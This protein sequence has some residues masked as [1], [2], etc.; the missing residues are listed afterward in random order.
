MKN[1]VLLLF[2]A[3]AA[4]SCS[5]EKKVNS[6]LSGT[7]EN[8][9]NGMVTLVGSEYE[10]DLILNDDGTF[11]SELELPY[12][13]Y[14]NAIF[15]RIPLA[16]YLEKGKD[17]SLNVDVEQFSESLDFSSDLAP[18]NKFLAEKQK[19]SQF[20]L[21][22]LYRKDADDFS[23]SINDLKEELNLKLETSAISNTNF[24]DSQEKEFLY[25]QAGFLNT[26]KDAHGYL[27]EKE[28]VNLPDDFYNPIKGIDLTDTLSFRKSDLYKQMLYGHLNKTVEEMPDTE[29]SNDNLQYIALVNENIPVGYAKN[30]LLKDA[31]GYNLKPDKYLDKV[32]ELYMANQTDP[33]LKQAMEDSYTSLS[34]IT[35][36]NE[37]PSFDYENF[38]GGT[39]SLE[40]LK[41]NYV[42]IDV[43]A[44]WC[45]PCLKEVP[46]LKE[47]EK[48]YQDKNISFVAISIDE[49]KD[50]EKWKEMVAE[51]ELVGI[52]LYSGGDAWKSDFTQ[53]YRVNSI[54][55]F[56][57]I[58]PEGK[59]YDADT[60][61]P[62]E[63]KLRELFDEILE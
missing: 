54:P 26:Y 47:V 24:I 12:D 7:V 33:E 38:K 15:G 63:S 21:Q 18:E 53:G 36:G 3:F 42:Y 2:A 37:S 19:L 6:L 39:T 14:Y 11:T 30:Q 22:E 16:L 40:S 45:M 48:D 25:Q 56:I 8:S 29:D 49:A 28:E 9:P 62:S 27:T 35:P 31:L 43:W 51:K 46:Y 5:Q 17:L 55:R 20:D 50:Y 32:Y 13:G 4:L 57:L 52:Q 34:K 44:T 10:K 60:Y 59:I 1:K 58:D 23:A 41:G 61:R